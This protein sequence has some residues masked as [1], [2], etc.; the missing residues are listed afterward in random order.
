M[1]AGDCA[2]TVEGNFD[3]V[4]CNPPFHRGF[5]VDNELTRHFLSAARK[6]L[7]RGG[8]AVF[9]VNSFIPIEKKLG[10]LFR[11]VQTLLNDRQFKVLALEI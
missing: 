5:D 3:L 10:G 6:K 8:V 9:V 4:L 2:D 1:I 11:K 7:D